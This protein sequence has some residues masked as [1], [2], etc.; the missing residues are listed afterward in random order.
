MQAAQMSRAG[1]WDGH[2]DAQWVGGAF[3]C[4]KTPLRDRVP[5]HEVYFE[6]AVEE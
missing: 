2:A 3:F 1:V 5:P 6:A 4:Q